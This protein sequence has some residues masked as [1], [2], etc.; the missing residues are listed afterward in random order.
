MQ[1][2]CDELGVHTAPWHVGGVWVVPIYSWYHQSWDTEP[3]V[4]GAAP[5]EKVRHGQISQGV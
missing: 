5:I 4:P 2:I 3:D 1:G